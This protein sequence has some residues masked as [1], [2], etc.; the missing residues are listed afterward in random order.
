MADE[1]NLLH[2]LTTP[3]PGHCYSEDLLDAVALVTSW[4]LVAVSV[5]GVI[6]VILDAAVT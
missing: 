6:A 4:V 3:H 2:Y 1:S 5:L